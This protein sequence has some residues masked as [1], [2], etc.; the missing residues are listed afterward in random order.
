MPFISYFYLSNA[1]N[2]Q[3]KLQPAK[4]A[5]GRKR[6]NDSQNRSEI[7]KNEEKEGRGDEKNEE[8]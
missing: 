2:H 4:R 8:R 1:V 7:E 3:L 5:R 6:E